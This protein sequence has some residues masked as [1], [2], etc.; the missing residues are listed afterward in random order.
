MRIMRNRRTGRWRILA[1]V[2]LLFVDLAGM[3]GCARLPITTKVVREDAR[4]VVKLQQEVDRTTY[5]HPVTLGQQDIA[6]ILKGFSLREDRGP[7]LRWYQEDIPP[8][9]VFRDDEIEALVPALVEAL[10]GAKVNERVAFEVRAPGNDPREEREVTAGW[11]AIR[12]PYFHLTVEFHHAQLPTRKS[13]T[14]ERYYPTPPPAPKSFSLYFEPG[15]FWVLDKT[16]GERVVDFRG[17]LQSAPVPRK[18]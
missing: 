9:P 16:F 7:L 18:N 2:I 6:A 5:S 8:I 4:V 11:L 12:D 10:Q 14:Y 15:R 13:M 17:F 3:E 1:A